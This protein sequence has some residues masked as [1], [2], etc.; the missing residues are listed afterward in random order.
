MRENK[1]GCWGGGR[2]RID[3]PGAVMVIADDEG[4]QEELEDDDEADAD[5]LMMSGAIVTCTT[6]RVAAAN[7]KFGFLLLNHHHK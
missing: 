6:F 4:G 3:F 7:I 2:F 1:D 5:I